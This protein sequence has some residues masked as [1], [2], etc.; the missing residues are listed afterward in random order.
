MNIMLQMAFKGINNI[1]NHNG[2]VLTLLVF[3]VYPCI[4]TDFLF[5]IF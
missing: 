5:I 1:A 3:G 4:I 2:L